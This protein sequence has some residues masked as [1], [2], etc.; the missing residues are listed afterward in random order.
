MN[1]DWEV[2]V[3]GDNKTSELVQMTFSLRPPWSEYTRTINVFVKN[4][5]KGINIG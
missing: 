5:I 4:P 2:L 3:S 1:K